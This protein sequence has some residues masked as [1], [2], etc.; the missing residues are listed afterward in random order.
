MV[1]L[2]DVYNGV[3]FKLL[4]ELLAQYGVSLRLTRWLAAALQETMIAMRLGNWIS[5]PKQLTMGIPHGSFLSPALYYVYKKAYADLNSNDLSRVLI[6]VDDRL[7]YKTVSD[8]HTAVTAVQEYCLNG[9]E[10]QSPK[11]V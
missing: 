5:T 7:I 10:R 3:H 11:S 8:N 2:E 4:V 1:D 9:A 6:L